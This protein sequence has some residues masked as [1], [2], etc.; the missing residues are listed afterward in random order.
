MSC[1]G[2]NYSIFDYESENDKTDAAGGYN[3]IL[4]GLL[5]NIV[6]YHGKCYNINIK[7]RVVSND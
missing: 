1:K 6:K 5:V 7:A 3:Y 2:W 4:R